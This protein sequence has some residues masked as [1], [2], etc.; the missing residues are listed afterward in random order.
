MNKLI[1]TFNGVSGKFFSGLARI[2]F[3]VLVA[4]A[5]FSILAIFGLNALYLFS[6]GMAAGVLVFV[7][8]QVFSATP[9]AG[10]PSQQEVT[11]QLATLLTMLA[12]IYIAIDRDD[13]TTLGQSWIFMYFAISV[14]EKFARTQW[15]LRKAS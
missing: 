15:A 8:W 6:A 2:I 11:V 12:A 3:Y 5:D 9:F 13:L 7:V 1:S 4:L 10:S 14:L